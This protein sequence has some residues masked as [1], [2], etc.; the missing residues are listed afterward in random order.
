MSSS[1]KW[2]YSKDPPHSTAVKGYVI[3][4]NICE[5]LKQHLAYRKCRLYFYRWHP[6]LHKVNLWHFQS[7]TTGVLMTPTSCIQGHRAIARPDLYSLLPYTGTRWSGTHKMEKRGIHIP[8]LLRTF[9]PLIRWSMKS[10][11]W[12]M[13][14]EIQSMAENLGMMVFQGSVS[15]SA[16]IMRPVLAPAPFFPKLWEGVD[17][18]IST[19]FSSSVYFLHK[20]LIFLSSSTLHILAN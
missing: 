13:T 20:V 1:I 6:R 10:M 2:T 12:W 11:S 3:Q 4:V 19:F 17:S 7:G 18:S 5:C 9:F 15:L 14:L 16:T 8:A